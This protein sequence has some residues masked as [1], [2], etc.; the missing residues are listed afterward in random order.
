M[1]STAP[2]LTLTNLSVF[3]YSLFVSFATQT[4]IISLN[5]NTRFAIALES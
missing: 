2:R 1:K 3:S 4:V 5:K